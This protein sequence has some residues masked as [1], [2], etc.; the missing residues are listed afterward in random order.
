MDP[1]DGLDVIMSWLSELG[2]DEMNIDVYMPLRSRSF[3]W[4]SRDSIIICV[5]PKEKMRLIYITSF[6]GEFEV[7]AGYI[8]SPTSTDMVVNLYDPE[9]FSQIREEIGI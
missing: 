3:M 4:E 5:T 8:N 7:R 2:Y 6:S 1:F 9:C